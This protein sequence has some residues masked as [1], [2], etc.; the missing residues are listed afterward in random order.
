MGPGRRLSSARNNLASLRGESGGVACGGDRAAA[1]ALA[2]GGA[3]V[4]GRGAAARAACIMRS[5]RED[6]GGRRS[7]TVPWEKS[8]ASSGETPLRGARGV[9]EFLALSFS[10]C[11]GA[12]TPSPSTAPISACCNSATRSLSAVVAV[13]SVQCMGLATFSGTVRAFLTDREAEFP[14]VSDGSTC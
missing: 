1:E 3:E 13:D 10:D 8:G 11:G 9:T 4:A 6:A 12:D 2:V 5:A 7:L 14:L